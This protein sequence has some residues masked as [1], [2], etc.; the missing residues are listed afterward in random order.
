MEEA[1]QIL[2]QAEWRPRAS[3]GGAWP[4][5]LQTPAPEDAAGASGTSSV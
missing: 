1:G 2:R 5:S 3:S 4:V